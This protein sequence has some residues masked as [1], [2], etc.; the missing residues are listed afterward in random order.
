MMTRSLCLDRLRRRSR[1]P[2][3]AGATAL[4]DLP[5]PDGHHAADTEGRLVA[6]DVPVL[7]QIVRPVERTCLTHVFLDGLTLMETAAR[8]GLPLGSVKTHVRRALQRLRE[9]LSRH[10]S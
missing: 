10:D 5:H 8:T 7:L 1:R 9:T 4:D 2:D 3:L 6:D